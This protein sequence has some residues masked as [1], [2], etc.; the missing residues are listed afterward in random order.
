MDNDQYVERMKD[1][2]YKAIDI[3]TAKDEKPFV[4]ISYR[5]SSWEWMT[6]VVYKLQ[7]QY[8]LRVYFD[9]SFASETNVWIKQFVENMDS[10][11]CKAMICFFDEGYVTSYATLLEYM[12]AKMTR[13]LIKNSVLSIN[14]SIDWDKL[15][16]DGKDTGLGK[17]NP[18]NP[19]YNMEKE[20]FDDDFKSLDS[21]NQFHGQL[22]EYYKP[23]KNFRICDCA[24]IMSIIQPVNKR[25]YV[26]N[27]EFLE[28]FIVDPLEDI[29]K[30][31]FDSHY[32][33]GNG[34]NEGQEEK[35]HNVQMKIAPDLK[36]Y[37]AKSGREVHELDR[38]SE[39]SFTADD[40]R[41]AFDKMLTSRPDKV[42]QAVYSL[43]CLMYWEDYQADQLHEGRTKN[44]FGSNAYH[45][46]SGGRKIA[47]GTNYSKEQKL[48][49]YDEL[50]QIC[51]EHATQE[52]VNAPMATNNS[53]NVDNKSDNSS[54][55]RVFGEPCD[56]SNQSDQ[57]IFIFNKVLERHPDKV[58]A[59]ISDESMNVLSE[60]DYLNYK[61]GSR[62]KGFIHDKK[63]GKLGSGEKLNVGNAYVG[64]NLSLDDKKKYVRKLLQ[65]CG[66]D[67]GIVEGF[68]DQESKS[69]GRRKSD[70]SEGLPV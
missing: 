43:P 20:E 65:F 64:K 63:T 15:F 40:M 2:E 13:S 70:E 7:K 59:L 42:E 27:N 11:Y 31:V 18:A 41:K 16:R 35:A 56:S 50:K 17:Q 67:E 49:Y 12:H 52:I 8:G 4:F 33:N 54:Q 14:R 37:Q 61:E 23:N 6:H 10:E 66:E 53:L 19:G 48:Q 29:C 39:A 60:D 5:S 34:K 45:F 3:T 1:E 44:T 51:E 36:D 47:I 38:Q 57:M 22:G 32:N 25:D 28:Q 55:V 58:S 46:E 26:K 24:H 21:P 9:K 30:D 69:K 68:F 62:H